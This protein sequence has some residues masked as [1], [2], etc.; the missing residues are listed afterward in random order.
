MLN[1]THSWVGTLD[2]LDLLSLLAT[3]SVPAAYITDLYL[4]Y[5]A[6]V[7]IRSDIAIPSQILQIAPKT[8]FTLIRAQ[9]PNAEGV[10]SERER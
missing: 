5:W 2:T 10:K 9:L 8:M 6:R 3:L 1:N 4:F 7:W